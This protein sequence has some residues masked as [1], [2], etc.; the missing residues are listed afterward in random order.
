VEVDFPFPVLVVVGP[1]VAEVFPVQVVV[2][3]GF[4][5][6]ELEACPQVA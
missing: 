3:E 1:Q 4:P 2:L 6:W 5:P